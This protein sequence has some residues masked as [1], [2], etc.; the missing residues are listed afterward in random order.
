[1]DAKVK[2]LCPVQHLDE[3]LYVAG[4]VRADRTLEFWIEKP[5]GK[6]WRAISQSVP[7]IR[8]IDASR[9]FVAQTFSDDGQMLARISMSSGWFARTGREVA[10]RANERNEVWAITDVFR[11][12]L[13]DA[14]MLH[15]EDPRETLSMLMLAA[16]PAPEVDINEILQ[17]LM[18]KL[19]EFYVTSVV[20]TV[21]DPFAQMPGARLIVAAYPESLRKRAGHFERPEDELPYAPLAEWNY[22]DRLSDRR[23]AMYMLATGFRTVVAVRISVATNKYIECLMFGTNSLLDDSQAAICA[24]TALNVMP[25]IKQAASSEVCNITARERACLLSAFNG[26]TAI[27]TANEISCTTRTVR[28]HLSNAMNKLRVTSTIAAIQRAQMLGI[29]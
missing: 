18:T 13:V 26:K 24:W 17:D 5:L 14:G 1:M 10:H 19:K 20:V 23:W 16:P 12:L 25:Q 3:E 4:A 15:D 8:D 6:M 11:A 27:E 28:L 29:L 21:P 7:G 9:E 2:M 22:L